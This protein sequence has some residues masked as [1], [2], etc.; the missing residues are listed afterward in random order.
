MDTFTRF[1]TLL[2]KFGVIFE[3]VNLIIV[4]A[5]W[6]IAI[7]AGIEFHGFRSEKGAWALLAVVVASWLL[8]R[9]VQRIL[10]FL[11]NSPDRERPQ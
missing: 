2:K 7:Q 5:I 4:I 6:A 11:R 8:W 10:A 9:S 3:Y 1:Y